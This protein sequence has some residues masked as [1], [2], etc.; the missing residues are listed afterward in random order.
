MD[1]G[2]GEQRSKEKLDL[3]AIVLE[4]WLSV[5]EFAGGWAALT[6]TLQLTPT[7][8]ARCCPP[9]TDILTTPHTMG[10]LRL[11]SIPGLRSLHNKLAE[12]S[13]L[14]RAPEEGGTKK[15]ERTVVSNPEVSDDDVPD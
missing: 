2:R 13:D 5:H 10:R 1:N 6:R 14:K 3:A 11:Q 8:S 7:L 4:N 15:E 9:A 12:H